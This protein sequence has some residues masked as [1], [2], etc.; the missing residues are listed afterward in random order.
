MPPWAGI[1]AS[2]PTLYVNM[3]QVGENSGTLDQALQRLADFLE[4]QARM[5][6][7][8]LAAMTYPLLMAWSAVGVLVFLFAFVVPKITRMLED[9]G[10]ALPLPTLLL[11]GASRFSQRLLVAAAAPRSAVAALCSG[12]AIAAPRRRQLRLRPAGCSTC[13]SSAA[14][15]C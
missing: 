15:I 5:R 1:R 13:P 11:I 12:A 2:S 4:E 10:Q 6:S 14:S 7:R 8:I 3:V 9:L